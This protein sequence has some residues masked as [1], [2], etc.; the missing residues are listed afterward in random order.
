[1]AC[2]ALLSMLALPVLATML[3]HVMTAAVW[4]AAGVGFL[5]RALGLFLG[6]T[7]MASH[8]LQVLLMVAR[9]HAAAPYREW[10][11]SANYAAAPSL[12]PVAGAL[13]QMPGS[14]SPY[15]NALVL[16]AVQGLVDAKV[17]TAA[18]W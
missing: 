10:L 7:C 15:K 1:M 17:S 18:A 8:L 2:D 13:L 14:L 16:G 6:L 11:W 3:L 9:P 5:P 12:L 4:P